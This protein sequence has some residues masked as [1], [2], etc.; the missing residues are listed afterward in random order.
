ME[1]YI[2]I[3][4]IWLWMLFGY[5]AFLTIVLLLVVARN[6]RRMSRFHDILKKKAQDL[7]IQIE[8]SKS[9]NQAKSDFLSRMSHEIRTPLNAII[10]MAQIA[11]NASEKSKIDDCMEK[12]ESNSKH[13]L[14]IINDILDFSKI[15]SG[16]LTLEESEFSLRQDIDFVIS[17][18][19]DRAKEKKLELQVKFEEIKHDG[20]TSDMLRLNQVLINLLSNAIKFTDSGGRVALTVEEVAHLD[21]ESIYRFIVQDTGVGIDP[22]QAE[23][24]FTPFTQANAGTTRIYGGTGLGLSI[25]QSIARMMGGEIEL[26]TELGQGSLFQFTI[27]VPAKETIAVT[28]R[29]DRL[30][31]PKKLENKRILVVDD[32]EINREI[33]I[34]MLDGSGIEID[35]AVNGKEA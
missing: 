24:L 35:T 19:K 34:A 30:V 12:M 4:T 18:F 3:N 16:S 27:R 8:K 31:L 14:G 32:I 23:K 2:W 7:E 20:I 10:G 29:D 21:G 5:I 22:E 15:E 26:E 9:A 11:R 33:I 13:L 28:E 17:M 1:Q 6:H 25:S